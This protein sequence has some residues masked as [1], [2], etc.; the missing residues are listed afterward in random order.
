MFQELNNFMENV[1]MQISSS[2]S[3][4]QLHTIQAFDP[5]Q[6]FPKIKTVAFAVA[7][8]AVV[9]LGLACA[10]AGG[11]LAGVNAMTMIQS[12]ALAP[13]VVVQFGLGALIFST[14]PNW[15]EL[16]RKLY[17][18][19]S[20]SP[21]FSAIAEA[22]QLIAKMNKKKDANKEPIATHRD[23]LEQAI[24]HVEEN[25]QDALKTLK[26]LVENRQKDYPK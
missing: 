5:I 22:N 9:I 18:G 12:K 3:A 21:A 4:A 8:I 26:E 20:R 14:F 24:L 1:I 23:E 10:G 15:M 13:V 2:S 17:S 7:T 19:W 11:F 16:A 6:N 25:R